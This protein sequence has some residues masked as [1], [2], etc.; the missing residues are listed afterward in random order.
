MNPNTL[1]QLIAAVGTVGLPLAA[2]LLADVNAGKTST[3]VTPADLLEIHRLSN[4]TS[5]EIYANQGI[6]PPPPAA[7]ASTT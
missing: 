5:A 2:K 4:L 3:T 7:Q 1:S 6:V